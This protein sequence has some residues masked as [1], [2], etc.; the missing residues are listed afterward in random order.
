MR[1]S[2]GSHVYAEEAP[3]TNSA[4]PCYFVNPDESIP[5][6][7]TTNPELV[8]DKSAYAPFSVGPADCVGKNV[9]LMEMRSVLTKTLRLYEIAPQPGFDTEKF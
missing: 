3:T 1:W 4:D 2:Q 6:C 8:L 7:W 9:A 5:S